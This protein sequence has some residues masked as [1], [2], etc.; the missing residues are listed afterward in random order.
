MRRD[1]LVQLL[2]LAA[3]QLGL[4]SIRQAHALGVT[5]SMLDHAVACGWIRR[6]RMGV[7]LVAGTQP[8]PWRAALAAALAGGPVSA[9]SLTSAATFHR[10]YGVAADRPELTV[11]YGVSLKLTGVT[12]HRSRT[13]L[14]GDVEQRHGVN[15]TTP[16]RTVID[17]A[18]RLHDPLLGKIVDE[19]TISRLWTPE[20]LSARLDQ[21][22]TGVPGRGELAR[23]LA[24]RLGEGNLDSQLEQRVLRVIKPVF[25]GYVLHP[26]VTIDGQVFDMDIAWFSE[27]VDG[28]V[29]GLAPRKNSQSKLLR[30]SLRANFLA[31]HGWRIVHFTHGMEDRTILAQ[32]A[33]F[34]GRSSR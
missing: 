3:T 14:P 5:N 1:V 23:V 24:V 9:I 20:Q 15:V 2:A 27:K 19:G 21:L 29:D 17:L 11:P 26:H 28:E 12:V 7:F 10:M 31:A 4:F 13:L 6:E 22:H 16:V 8:S 30:T 33:P 25:P 18:A 32:L 34:L